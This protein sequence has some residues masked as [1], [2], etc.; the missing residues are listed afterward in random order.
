MACSSATLC[1]KTAQKHK[2]HFLGSS[3]KLYPKL[4]VRINKSTIFS[5]ISLSVCTVL[6]GVRNC[7][8]SL[9]AAKAPSACKWGTVWNSQVLNKTLSWWHWQHFTK[10]VSHSSETCKEPNIGIYTSKSMQ[11]RKG[12]FFSLLLILLLSVWHIP[13][14][15]VCIS[16][17]QNEWKKLFSGWCIM[18]APWM[19]HTNLILTGLSLRR[20]G[21]HEIC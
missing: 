3:L 4:G 5:Y 8:Q 10:Q 19:W 17:V 6:V 21:S 9:E 11:I 2:T 12:F 13:L 14:F 18:E 1:Q 15:N 20:R 7:W 16:E